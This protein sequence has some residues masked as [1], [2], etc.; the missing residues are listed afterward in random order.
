MGNI[1]LTNLKEPNCICLEI[2]NTE[3]SLMK[4]NRNNIPAEIQNINKHEK[5]SLCHL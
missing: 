2:I 1:S 4:M 5:H 3:K